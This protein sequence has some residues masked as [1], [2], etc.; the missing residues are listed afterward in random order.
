MYIPPVTTATRPETSPRFFV[1]DGDAILS[2]VGMNS[3]LRLAINTRSR[4]VLLWYTNC[5]RE[6]SGILYDADAPPTEFRGTKALLFHPST[7]LLSRQDY[8][9]TSEAAPEHSMT[10]GP[11]RESR[12]SR[13]SPTATARLTTT[14]RHYSRTTAPCDVHDSSHAHHVTD[15]HPWCP[16]NGYT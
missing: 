9:T 15:P 13:P 3:I 2:A 5:D 14:T 6:C 12:F 8:F 7:S 4:L 1:S 10:K 11:R 16:R